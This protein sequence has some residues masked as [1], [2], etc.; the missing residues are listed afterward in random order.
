MR[1]KRLAAAAHALRREQC[2]FDTSEEIEETNVTNGESSSTSVQVHRISTDFF[3]ILLSMRFQLLQLYIPFLPLQTFPHCE[4]FLRLPLHVGETYPLR[5]PSLCNSLLRRHIPIHSLI[6]I[7]STAVRYS[8][9]SPFAYFLSPASLLLPY[10]EG[11][12]E[13]GWHVVGRTGPSIPSR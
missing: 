3:I 13:I 2:R 6:V 8:H 7:N 9:G 10:E 12:P 5:F 11:V 4:I 1:E